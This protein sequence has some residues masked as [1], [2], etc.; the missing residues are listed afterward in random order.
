MSKVKFIMVEKSRLEV[1]G[2]MAS[3]KWLLLLREHSPLY[4]VQD[5]SLGSGLTHNCGKSYHISYSNQDNPSQACPQVLLPE[6]SKFCQ[7][8]N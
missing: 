1:T 8:D 2:H 7:A 3:T 4:T 5:P 6:D